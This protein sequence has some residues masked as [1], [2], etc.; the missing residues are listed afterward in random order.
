MRAL[1]N[2]FLSH[3]A[4]AIT[5]SVSFIFLYLNIYEENVKWMLFV[6]QRGKKV[7][8]PYDDDSFLRKE[9]KK[10]NHA[11]LYVMTSSL[12]SLLST[13]YFLLSGALKVMS[14]LN[15]WHGSILV[16][17]WKLLIFFSRI[18]IFFKFSVTLMMSGWHCLVW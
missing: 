10:T 1:G 9:E 7:I 18:L 16:E 4:C 2:A 17:K 5:L 14:S 11:I 3:L 12:V 6:I 13:K 15:T 8:S